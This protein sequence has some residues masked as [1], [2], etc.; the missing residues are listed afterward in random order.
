MRNIWE[1][2]IGDLKKIK[3]MPLHGLLFWGLALFRLFMRGLI[4]QQVGILTVTQAV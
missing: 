3:K 1:I 4:L 2:F